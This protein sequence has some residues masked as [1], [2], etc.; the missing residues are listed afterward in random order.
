MIDLPSDQCRSCKQQCSKDLGI[1]MTVTTVQEHFCSDPDR[2]YADEMR[3]RPSQS[4]LQFGLPRSLSARMGKMTQMTD[5]LVSE[6]IIIS[7]FFFYLL[8]FSGAVL[9]AM[10]QLGE[11]LR[12]QLAMASVEM[13]WHRRI[14]PL[15]EH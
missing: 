10:S 15:F 7:M 4:F 12:S 11:R 6:F 13:R 8:V 3:L 5:E 2:S 14:A 1:D 9:R